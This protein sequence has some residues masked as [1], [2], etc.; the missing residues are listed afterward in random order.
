MKKLI[1]KAVKVLAFLLVLA[2]CYGLM[3]QVLKIK[4]DDMVSMVKL[5]QLPPDT[6]DVLLVGSSHIGMN[7]DNQRIFDEYG[8]ASYNLWVG[9]QPLWNSYYYLEEALRY[10]KPKVVLM[11]VFLCGTT[12]EYSAPETAMKNIELLPF[13]IEKIRAALDSFENWTDAAEAVWGLPY[14]HERYDEITQDDLSL[15]YGKDDLSLFTPTTKDGVVTKLNILDYSAITDTLPLTEKNERYLK[16]TIELCKAQGIKLVLLVSPY[17]ATEEECMRLNS[18]A[19]LAEENGV[20]FL[21]YL[22]E[23]NSLGIDPLTDFYDIGHLN[24]AGIAKYST[25]MGAY[26]QSKYTLR[27]CRTVAGHIWNSDN[28]H[29]QTASSQTPSYLLEE[30]FHGDGVSEYIDTGVHL[31]GNRYGAWTLLTRVDMNFDREGDQIF[32]SCFNEEGGNN[33]RGLILRGDRGNIHLILGSNAAIQMPTDIG[34]EM[35]LAIAKDGEKYTVYVNGTQLFSGYELPCDAYSGTLLLGCEELTPGGEKFRF[36]PTRV[37]N[38]EVYDSVLKD[39]E[40]RAW[41]PEDLP[42]A[43]K[44]LGV[45]VKDAAEAYTLPEQFV[46]GVETYRQ[47]SYLDTQTRL[48]AST[49]TRF[50]LLT[51][52][53]PSENPGNGVFLSCFDENAQNY[54]GLLIRQLDNA[55]INI[56]FGQNVGVTVSGEFDREMHLT[57]VKDGKNYRIYADGQLVAEAESPAESYDGTLL[58]GAQRD[59][60]GNIFRIS[61]TRVNHLSLYAGVMTEADIAAYDFAAAPLP[62]ELVAESAAYT[63]PGAFVGNGSDRALDT[64]VKLYDVAMKDW[65]LDTVIDVRKGVNNGV[66]MSCFSEKI[67]H[68]RGFM[69]RQDNADTLTVYVGNSVGVTVDLSQGASL[70][71]LVVVKSGSQYTIWQDGELVQRVE[72]AC[73]NY[74]ATLLLGAQRDA[75][76]NLFRFSNAGIRTLNI[77]DG[78][79]SDTDAAALSAPVKDNSRF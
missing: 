49:A 29:H 26:L 21:N 15:N 23:W 5:R 64:G 72:S 9:M 11:D 6:V 66:Y 3:D 58:I 71:H 76:G 57:I 22:K 14:Y 55:Q 70:M 45:G 13:G 2:L 28:T 12:A 79:L 61:K 20:T 25:W 44:P 33:F 43:P 38:L 53:T 36:S 18:V 62:P 78:A 16:K 10:Q 19:K 39:S 63:M 74:D 35:L 41:Q 69:L 75:D 60:D 56:V 47:A 31:Y 65:T 59:A 73:D 37:L 42:E 4:T 8:I 24:N 52:V 1:Q 68:Y 77:T 48:F 17:E 30:T 50:T 46:G 7:I 32:L 51:S 67:G 54:R 27:D 34:D 40:I